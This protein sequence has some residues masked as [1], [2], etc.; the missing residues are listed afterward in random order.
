MYLLATSGYGYRK[1]L[2]ED[3]VDWFITKFLPRH[4]LHIGI[5]HKGLKREEAYGFC[6]VDTDYGD[7]HRPRD[8]S[9]DLQAHMSHQLYV[10]TLL[11]ELVHL[12]QWVIGSLREKRGRMYYDKEL[13][14]NYEYL[15]QPHE[16]EARKE[17]LILYDL[18]TNDKEMGTVHEAA[19]K[20]P[21]RIQFVV[22]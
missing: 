18:Y 17:E 14:N 5:E 19:H 11:H 7:I 8:F 2:C 21:N 16:I 22:Y 15:Y 9:I 20:S 10:T 3:V 4:K 13:V 12:K 6:D 1:Q